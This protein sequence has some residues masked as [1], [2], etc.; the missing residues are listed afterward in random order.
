MSRKF[1]AKAVP[2]TWLE[3]HGRRLDCGPYLSGAMEARELLRKLSVPKEPLISITE[4]IYHAGRES[5]LW[6]NSEEHGISFM[7][8]TDILAS[9]FT[10][11]PLI[12]NKQ[13]RSNPKFTIRSGWTLI[14]RSGTIGRMAYA[15]DDMDGVACSEHVMRVVP[16]TSKI[17]PGYIFAYLSSRFGLPIV[18]SGTYGSIIQSIEPHHISDLPVPR[19]GNIENESHLLVQKAANLRTEASRHLADAIELMQRESG[20]QKL[21]AAAASGISFGTRTVSSSV[22]FSRMDGSFHSLFHEEVLRSLRTADVGAKAVVDIAESIF[23]PKRFKRV[24]VED[25]AFGIPMFGTTA[26][27]WADP[28]PSFFLPKSMPG[29]NELVVDKR[30]V[31]IPRSGQVSG[32]IGTAVLP[33]GK[34]V[35]GAVSEHA[36]RV[37]CRE[38]I[39]AGYLLVALRSEYGIRQLKSRAYGSSIPSLDVRQVGET[40]VPDLPE[41]V[42]EQIGALGLR[43]AE[44]RGRAID[45]ENEARSLVERTIEEGGR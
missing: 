35:G 36:I 21:P 30:T 43:S 14:T 8:S 13:V 12:S 40:L 20:L 11:L 41:D 18:L 6:V 28:Q 38:D 23:E 25:E 26:L 29:V 42:F 19:L 34:L 5:R 10:S 32:I 33:F 3:S 17:R 22:L 27:M 31:L 39:D 24:Q 16:N 2:S 44:L 9:D 7:G 4:G 45:L 15:R 37:H 1:Q